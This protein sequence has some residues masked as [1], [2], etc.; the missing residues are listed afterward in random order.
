MYHG[1]LAVQCHVLPSVQCHGVPTIQ[2]H[3]ICPPWI[4]QYLLQ[5]PLSACCR[6][7]LS[8]AGWQYP[9]NWTAEH[10]YSSIKSIN[11]WNVV[12]T[13]FCV[14]WGYLRRLP[15]P[16]WACGRTVL[17]RQT[18]QLLFF[19]MTTSWEN[20]NQKLC[21]VPERDSVTKMFVSVLFSS[22]TSPGLNRHA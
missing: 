7:L 16:A 3:G 12:I 10:K 19:L 5:R 22:T 1:M 2:F 4:S 20:Q 17:L 9:R 21:Y 18:L 13:C 8:L 6:G 15:N 14:P 11:H